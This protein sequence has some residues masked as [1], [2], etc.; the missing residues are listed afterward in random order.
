MQSAGVVSETSVL[1]GEGKEGIVAIKAAANVEGIQKH[2]KM[3]QNTITSIT[4]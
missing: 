2:M 4:T 1:T 3:Y